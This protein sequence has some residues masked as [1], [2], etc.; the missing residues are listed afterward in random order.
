M[1]IRLNL[2]AEAQAAEEVR[3]RDP[4]KRGIWIAGL[5]VALMLVWSSSLQV[6]A[7][8]IRSKLSGLEARVASQTN[9]YVS[10]LSDQTK[11]IETGRKL[12][13]LNQLTTNRFLYGS[14]LNALQQ[15]TVDYVQL[16]HL[17]VDQTYVY[18]QEIKSRT[19]TTGRTV[20]GKPAT[21]TEKIVITLEAKD[22]SPNPGDQVNKYRQTI[23]SNP[24]IES[25]L[26]K[27]NE[28]KLARYSTP[29]AIPGQP[30]FVSFALEC[31]LPEK[32]R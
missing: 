1:P 31:T 3:R 7:V 9:E 14:L 24:F 32:T 28:V 22:S 5:L 26:G 19:N 25:L 12:D 20:P 23:A 11:W 17:R 2:L 8:M 13:A 16:V 18:T 4:V 10:V 6:R 15:T 21:A 29:T 27:T 30:G